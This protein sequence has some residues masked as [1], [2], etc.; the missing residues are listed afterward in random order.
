MNKAVRGFTLIELMVVIGIIGI[1]ATI[2]FVGARP[3]GEQSRDAARQSDLRQVETALE[4]Y[5]NKHGRYPEGCNAAGTWSGQ[6]GTAY[7]CGTTSQPYILGSTV[8]NRPFAAFMVNLPQDPKLNGSNS[9]YVYTTNADGSVYKF[10]V[11]NTVE[12]EVVTVDHP[13]KSCDVGSSGAFCNSVAPSN[14]RPNHCRTG[15]SQF[16]SSYAVWGGLDAPA[17]DSTPAEVEQNTED[18][19]CEIQ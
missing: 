17:I 11:K 7:A 9:G 14:S 18:I 1:L 13:F 4:L 6:T 19:I 5:K 2:S 12:S 15:N 10:M 16:Q 8:D 3:A